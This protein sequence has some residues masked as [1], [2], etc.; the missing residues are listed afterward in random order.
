M[1]GAPLPFELS[2]EDLELS[3]SIGKGVTAEVFRGECRGHV[4]AIKQLKMQSVNTRSFTREIGIMSQ[5]DHPNIVKL[6]GIVLSSQPFHIVMEYCSG[7]NAF[8]LLHNQPEIELTWPQMLRMSKHCAVAMDYL[9]K[10]S[11]QIIHRD[12]KSLNLLLEKPVASSMDIPLLKVT[13][14]GLARMMEVSVT[15]SNLT[16]GVGTPYWMAPEVF[17]GSAYNE[18]VDVYSFGMVLFEILA[19]RIPLE[20]IPPNEVRNAVLQGQTPNL[21]AIPKECPKCLLDLLKQCWAKIAAQRP[22]FGSI[23]N[24]IKSID[25]HRVVVSL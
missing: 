16:S 8:D 17:A 5:I 1:G 10:F 3:E 11:P 2:Y 7:G 15:E 20:E 19:R 25:E 12:L 23:V 18:K 9:H 24:T 4:V 13:D 6:L 22:A 21:R 14:F